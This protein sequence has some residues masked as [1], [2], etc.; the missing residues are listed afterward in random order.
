VLNSRLADFQLAGD[1]VEVEHYNLKNKGVE[2]VAPHSE[3]KGASAI[4]VP[5]SDHNHRIQFL[6]CFFKLANLMIDKHLFLLDLP[7]IDAFE[8]PKECK[9]LIQNSDSLIAD[10][11]DLYG[12]FGGDLGE[13]LEL[14]AEDVKHS[15]SFQA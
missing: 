3:I 9:A 7:D 10:Y 6:V 5:A 2:I 13:A 8:Y 11:S 12:K 4:G 15:Y 1:N 14:L